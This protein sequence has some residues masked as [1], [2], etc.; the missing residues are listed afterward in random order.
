MTK[1]QKLKLLIGPMFAFLIIAGSFLTASQ[2]LAADGLAGAVLKGVGCAGSKEFTDPG[3]G[4]TYQIA[5]DCTPCDLVRVAVNV[6]DL[7][8]AF[9]G[10]IMLLIF[11]YAGI[12][13]ILSYANPG[14]LKQAKEAIKYGLIGLVLIFGAYTF[15]NFLLSALYGGVGDSSAV[16]SV[17][18]SMTGQ[19]S[20]GVCKD[21]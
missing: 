16:N 15:V 4:N 5:G 14:F 2:T 8:V 6:S 21:R 13:M 17:I 1:H 18:S 9:S 3:T 19:S 20:W 11:I 7:F 10:L 12:L